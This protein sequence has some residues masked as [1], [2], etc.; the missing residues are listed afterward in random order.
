MACSSGSIA[1]EPDELGLQLSGGVGVGE[2]RPTR[3]RC[4]ARFGAPSAAWIGRRSPGGSDRCRLCWNE[5]DDSRAGGVQRDPAAT[6]H[7][8]QGPDNPAHW[9][10]GLASDLDV[11]D[12][13]VPRVITP[14]RWQL[15][16]LELW[17]A[18]NRGVISVVTGAG[19]TAFALL[20]FE[21]L[22]TRTPDV[23]LVVIVPTLALLDQWVIALSADFGLS[24]DDIATFSGESKAR[25]PRL[26]NVIVLNTARSVASRIASV[27]ECLFVVDECHRA[28]S[29]ENAKA[30]QVDASYRLGLSATPVRDF[31]DGFERWVEPSLGPIIFEYGYSQA[32][33]DGVI[34]PLSLHNFRFS[35]TEPEEER[36]DDL[37][38]K[39]ARRWAQVD[40]PH[41]D[42]VLKRLLFRRTSIS[43]ESGRR[44]VACIA[45]AE[46]YEGRGIIFH[47]RI[48]AAEKI[49]RILDRR[50]ERV[51]LYHSHLA[52]AIRRRNLEL[53]R[54]GQVSKLVTCRAL[55]E[56]L[57]VPD[58]EVAIIG[59][60]TR[61]TRQRIQRLG[62]VVRPSPHKKTA[63]VCTL[64][65][66]ESEREALLAEEQ[67]LEESAEVHWYEVKS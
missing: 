15:D 60:S 11:Q 52:P 67:R 17:S 43:I 57:N 61:S 24:P 42:D 50:G 66:T 8:L 63:L 34:A 39:I 4:L 18:T 59:A 36:Y 38:K 30:L 2:T 19:K 35:L 48:A 28:G 29:P 47:E 62:R 37:S 9:M 20:A 49:A 58:A 64:Y 54:F 22:R 3:R 27:P 31:D 65:A 25:A 53:F 55:D 13:S 56:G 10:V 6:P 23:R 40:N 16:A 14:R 7:F 32:L 26:A 5:R 44:I 45:V 1:A 51:A 33:A 21:R 12:G 46:R 41:Q